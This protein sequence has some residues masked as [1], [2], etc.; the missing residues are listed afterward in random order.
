MR[1]IHVQTLAEE[2]LTGIWQYTLAQ[3]SAEQADKYLDDLDQGI[4]LLAKNAEIGAKRDDVRKGYRVLFIKSHA[5]YYTVTPTMVHVIRVLHS[6]MDP[7]RH[8]APPTLS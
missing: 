2:D 8:L 3:W 7:A 5:V 6:R 4:Q 1:K